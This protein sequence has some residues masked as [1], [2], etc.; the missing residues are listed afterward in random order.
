[1]I[2]SA[3]FFKGGHVRASL[4]VGSL[5][6]VLTS[7][8]RA[9]GLEDVP[10][11]PIDLAASSDITRDVSPDSPF[12][13]LV[14]NVAPGGQYSYEIRRVVHSIEPLELL[15]TQAE[16]SPCP[17]LDSALEALQSA[18]LK[19]EKVDAAAQEVRKQLSEC[20]NDEILTDAKAA[21]ART[22]VDLGKTSASRGEKIVVTIR[23][24]PRAW[25][26][27]FDAG[28]R[29]EWQGSYGFIYS[30][31]DDERY[32]TKAA[33]EGKFQITREQDRGGLKFMPMGFY[34]WFPASRENHDFAVGGTG[35][36]GF[37]DDRPAVALG[38]TVIFNR[39]L[40]LMG[41]VLVRSVQ[42]LNGQ[43]DV[44]ALPEVGENLTEAQLHVS[45]YRPTGF[46]GVSFRFGESP[47]GKGDGG[48]SKPKEP[49]KAPEKSKEKEKANEEGS[50]KK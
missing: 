5:I 6:L 44:D 32:F 26:A 29:G 21:L 35:G 20:T 10:T 23:R 24:G 41:G 3:I 17:Q 2:R 8:E 40:A 38:L 14:I 36:L 31:S 46:I 33:G 22:T 43:Y 19:E 34:S 13:I 15:R 39:N 9:T 50:T 7:V 27:T 1:M 11:Q 18:D 37:Q 42:R 25:T 4:I 16:H 48:S 28:K 47:F 12:R 45:T 49:A 30:P